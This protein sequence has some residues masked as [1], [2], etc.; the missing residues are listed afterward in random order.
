MPEAVRHISSAVVT[1]FP[2][3]STAVAA[4]I[5]ALPDTEIYA[6]ENGKIV[7]VMEGATTGEIGGRLAEIA[8]MEGVLTANLV[9]EQIDTLEIPGDGP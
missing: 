8:L 9:F 6:I 4:R 1:A 3:A 2:E 5:L 7:V